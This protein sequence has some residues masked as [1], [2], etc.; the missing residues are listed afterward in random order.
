MAHHTRGLCVPPA[1]AVTAVVVV[2]DATLD[3]SV[4][5]VRPMATGAD[6]PAAIAMR[7]G[8]QGANVAVR[9]ARQGIE[10]TLVCALGQDPAG[11]MIRAALVEDGVSII[12]VP[13]EATGLI[14]VISGEDGERSML[15]HRATLPPSV[16]DDVAGLSSPWLAVSGYPLLQPD[17]LDLAGRL[18]T[19][20]MRRALLGCAVADEAMA[21]WVSAV[22]RLN[23]DLVIAN[24]QEADRA[25]LHALG[26]VLA[27]TAS[28]GANVRA[29]DVHVAAATTPGPAAVD[30]TGAG[31]AFAAGL[32][33]SLI[34]GPWPPDEAHLQGSVEAGV[35][36]ASAV[37]RVRGAQA[38]VPG[39]RP[40]RLLA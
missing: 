33:A 40:A 8:G 30:T 3:V 35:A 16:A 2:G 1:A 29:G 13:A 24:R 22:R 9:L 37:A 15:S 11:E 28:A 10:V 17:A 26:A 25:G 7:P 36:L 39:E 19:L 27:I 18:A 4:S 31:D 14:V 6:V 23:P 38:R 32:L 21:A 5:P 20:P 34:G 12:A